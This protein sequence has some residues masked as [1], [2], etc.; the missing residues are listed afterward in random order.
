MEFAIHVLVVS[1]QFGSGNRVNEIRMTC[2]E[3]LAIFAF[4]DSLLNKLQCL[5]HVL[6]VNGILN[7]I[8]AA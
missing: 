8:V 5:L 3:K 4:L 7:L 6:R 1:R 2:L